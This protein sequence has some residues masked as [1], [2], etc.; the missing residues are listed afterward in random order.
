MPKEGFL[1]DCLKIKAIVE[2]P[3]PTN[4][5]KVRSFLGS[6]NYYRRF[7]KGYAKV[8]WP[9]YDLISG[10]NAKGKKKAIQWTKEEEGNTVDKRRQPNFPNSLNSCTFLFQ[11]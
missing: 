4:V 10:D 8:A 9:L 6:A 5:T 2:L 7:I 11:S 3:S 1:M